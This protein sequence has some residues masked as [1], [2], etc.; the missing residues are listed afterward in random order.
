MLVALLTTAGSIRRRD[1]VVDR[2]IWQLGCAA[3]R[4]RFGRSCPSAGAFR[5]RTRASSTLVTAARLPELLIALGVT[6]PER[7]VFRV[8]TRVLVGPPSVD[9]ICEGVRCSF[10]FSARTARNAAARTPPTVTRSSRSTRIARAA[11]CT[12]HSRASYA[13]RLTPYRCALAKP[14]RRL[15]RSA[16]TREAASPTESLRADTDGRV[17]RPAD[18]RG[19]AASRRWPDHAHAAVVRAA[20]RVDAG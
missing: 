7:S 18:L 16:S 19:G 9:C 8:R 2:S 14:P 13:R 20:S 1:D 3:V 12:A 6:S 11:A 10:R 15:N 17:F 5:S 4:A